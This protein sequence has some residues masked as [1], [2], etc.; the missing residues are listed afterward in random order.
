MSSFEDI[1]R[2]ME[3]FRE[4]MIEF[5][6][7]ILSIPAIAPESD[8]TGEMKKAERIIELVRDWGFDSIERYDAPDDRVPEGKRP[9]VL[10][11]IKGEDPE[12]PRVWTFFHTDVVPPGDLG[13]WS[14]DPYTLRVEGDRLIARG[15]EDNGQ[16]LIASLFA[17]RALLANG[18]RPRRDINIFLVAD[19]EVGSSKGMVYLMKEHEDLFSKNDLY[20]VP[21]AGEPDGS[22]IEVAEKSIMWL[23]VRTFGKQ[24]HASVPH[25]GVNANLAA[26]RFL[27]GIHDELQVLY[28]HEDLLYDYPRSSFV[29]SKREANVPNVNSIPGEDVSYMDCR[30]MPNYRA[31][32]VLDLI[33]QRAEEHSKEHGVRMEVDTLQYEQAAPPTSPDHPVVG[34]LKEAI[35]EVYGVEAKP[36]GIGGGTC[37][38]IL[39]RAG[40]PAAVWG[41]MEDSAHQ[42][43][44]T[45]LLSNYLGD[46]KVFARVFLT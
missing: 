15:I 37:A 21:D 13:K 29:P 32:E 46:A 10:L 19:E 33:R 16:D 23:K 36:Q 42:P 9:N 17:A 3:G 1:D 34:I 30:I 26:M 25:K 4:E 8:G 43:D 6:R 44:E 2:T 39:R 20:I 31:Q 18:R 7:D 11:R 35:G 38:A 14:G 40:Y 45:A 28:P 22:M 24:V 5:A 12:L 41:K 27:V